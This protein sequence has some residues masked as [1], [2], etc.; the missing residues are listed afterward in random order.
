METPAKGTLGH[1]WESS[2]V[3]RKAQSSSDAV[4]FKIP[5]DIMTWP[6]HAMA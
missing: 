6:K 1:S 5:V 2:V 4:D 3:A